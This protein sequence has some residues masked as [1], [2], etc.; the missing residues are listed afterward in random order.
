MTGSAASKLPELDD[1]RRVVASNNV[2]SNCDLRNRIRMMKYS[3][4][5]T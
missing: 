3:K 4:A 1:Q 5:Q 2:P